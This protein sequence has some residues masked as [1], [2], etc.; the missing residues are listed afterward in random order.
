MVGECARL[1]PVGAAS[2]FGG[3]CCGG[4][5]E[6]ARSGEPCGGG[7]CATRATRAVPEQSGGCWCKSASGGA[8]GWSGV[9]VVDAAG[10][11]GAAAGD[12]GP[13]GSLRASALYF[14]RPG[15]SGTSGR[16]CGAG[17]SSY[18]TSGV[19]AVACGGLSARAERVDAGFRGCGCY[20]RGG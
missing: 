1:L 7:V 17:G 4:R 16:A 3:V 9:G 6:D 14:R 2:V 12:R 5:S 8:A 11:R 10:D 19:C 18:P 13:A 20:V 15:A